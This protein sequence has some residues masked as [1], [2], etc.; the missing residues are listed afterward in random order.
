MENR[1]P[2]RYNQHH[3]PPSLPSYLYISRHS[4][5][6]ATGVHSAFSSPTALL[7]ASNTGCLCSPRIGI[8]S[9]ATYM[10]CSKH[11]I[12]HCDRQFACIC[13]RCDAPAVAWIFL[14]LSPAAATTSLHTSTYTHRENKRCWV[15]V[16][17]LE[18]S[19]PYIITLCRRHQSPSRTVFEDFDLF[20]RFCVLGVTHLPLI[21]YGHSRAISVCFLSFLFHA[22]GSSEN[23]KTVKSG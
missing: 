19:L 14:L 11:T 15:C 6:T 17:F 2:S 3:H 7:L 10:I 13:W 9:T 4:R 22:L 1:A 8:V 18:L 23:K 21:L 12:P 20:P 5:R 16:V